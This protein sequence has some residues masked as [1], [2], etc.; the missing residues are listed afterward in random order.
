MR[1]AHSV[2]I[3]SIFDHSWAKLMVNSL[4]YNCASNFNAHSSNFEQQAPVL[5]MP[6]QH[7]FQWA[8]HL[9]YFE[10]EATTVA[11]TVKQRGVAK[12]R[13]GRTWVA[14][15]ALLARRRRPAARLYGVFYPG[16]AAAAGEQLHITRETLGLSNLAESAVMD[17]GTRLF[18]PFKASSQP[19]S[20]VPSFQRAIPRQY[21]R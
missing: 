19:G 15:S 8:S 12:R 17:W 6:L 11:P 9:F 16:R 5:S 10:V 14:K 13:V 18:S 1:S 7:A 4:C 3:R 20:T 21:K 2:G